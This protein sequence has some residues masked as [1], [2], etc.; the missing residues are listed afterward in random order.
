[1]LFEIRAWLALA[2][3]L[4]ILFMLVRDSS[5]YLNEDIVFG[6]HSD[7]GHLHKL[8][9][10]ISGLKFFHAIPY[11]RTYHQPHIDHENASRLSQNNEFYNRF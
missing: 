10:L 3:R 11:F 5:D 8:H 1:M 9:H 7:S 4:A 6:R 2:V